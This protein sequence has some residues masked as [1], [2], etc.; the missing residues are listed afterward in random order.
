MNLGVFDDSPIKSP[1]LI[2]KFL[3]A[4]FTKLMLKDKIKSHDTDQ[5]E[6]PVSLPATLNCDSLLEDP[7]RSVCDS[8]RSPAHSQA[9]HSPDTQRFVQE[10]MDQGLP[11]IPF[12]MPTIVIAE[13]N[14]ANKKK[15]PR[16]SSVWTF[17]GDSHGQAD[18]HICDGARD[19]KQIPETKSHVEEGGGRVKQSLDKLLNE[20]KHQ[21]EQ[22]TLTKRKVNK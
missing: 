11:I 5:G 3:R 19:M 22:E 13:K 4:S 8:D 2:P 12:P 14:I 1:N 17:R 7:H 6:E 18:R 15:D 9:Q 21:L 10:S 20:A 16:R